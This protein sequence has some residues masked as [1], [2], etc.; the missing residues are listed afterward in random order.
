MKEQQEQSKWYAYT[1]REPLVER[2]W[3][4]VSKTEE[5]W[6]WTGGKSGRGVGHGYFFLE[7]QDGKQ[8][9]IYAHR[10]SALLAFGDFE[11]SLCVLHKCDNT[12]CVNPDH[13]WLGTHQDNMRDMLNKGRHV[14][15]KRTPTTH[16]PAGHEYSSENT[17]VWRSEKTGRSSKKCR[18]CDRIRHRKRK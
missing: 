17:H 2:F 8:I 15:G 3:S 14:P 7:R 12:I 11:Q 16:C 10:F 6:E 9:F 1:F 18:T 4:K 5:C 13:L